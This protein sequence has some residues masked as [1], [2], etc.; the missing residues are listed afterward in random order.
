MLS[1]GVL[2][3]TKATD[4][5]AVMDAISKHELDAKVSVLISDR[6]DA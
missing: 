6:K 1:I 4:L 3:S 5:Q 2:A